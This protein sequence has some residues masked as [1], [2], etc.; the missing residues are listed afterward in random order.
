MSARPHILYILSDEHRGQAMGHAGA[1][2]VQTPWMDRLASEG[3]SFL[4][5]GWRDV[6]RLVV[7]DAA[8]ELPLLP[9]E[10]AV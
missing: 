2:N 9:F 7:Y 5:Y 6:P 3:V 8:T 10:R 4:R 1:P